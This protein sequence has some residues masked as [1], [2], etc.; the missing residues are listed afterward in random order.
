MAR[1]VFI[2]PD[3]RSMLKSAGDRPPLG[4]LYIA[5]NLLL[6]RQNHVKVIDCNHTSEKEM[7]DILKWFDPHYVGISFT[8]PLFEESVRLAKKIKKAYPYIC[9]V[10]GGCHASAAPEETLGY[11]DKVVVGEGE[12]GFLKLLKVEYPIT[13]EIIIAEPIRSISELPMPARELVD[14]NHYNM[15][16]DG[17]R[18]ATLISSRGCTGNCIYCSRK[19]LGNAFRANTPEN[20]YIEVK[21][22]MNTYG[23]KS[24]YFCDDMFTKNK[25]RVMRIC[26]YLK[27]INITFRITTRADCV[28]REM[29]V[30]MKDA[31][32]DII[33][34]GIEH[35]DNEVLR[36]AGKG[37]VI[38]DNEK[39][40]NMCNELGIKV[41]GF[42]IIN[43]P[44][45]TKETAIKTVD[46]A[47]SKNLYAAHFYP[48]TA[49]PGSAL[50]TH[51][52]QL[53]MR[54]LDRSYKYIQAGDG[55]K[56]NVDSEQFPKEQVEE[57]LK[58]AYETAHTINN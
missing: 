5:S 35:A 22:L 15:I 53:G 23:Y 41:K 7:M 6:R 9:I 54:M 42:F 10:A 13:K 26:D 24:F 1:I 38:E 4:I 48:L 21:Q 52:E 18:T 47:R 27:R 28:D 34:L 8:T 46:W 20:V 51:T 56:I 14:M 3:E 58:Y 57:V 49:Y 32:L 12:T 19:A 36:K 31:G 44:G 45:A 17:L 11:F 37:M 40:I 25:K 2:S 29:L 39:V 55:C 30:A 16:Q 43:L 50:W 33:S